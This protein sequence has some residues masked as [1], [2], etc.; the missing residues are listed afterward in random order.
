VSTALAVFLI[1]VWLLLAMLFL[2]QARRLEQDPS[3]ATDD[4]PPARWRLLGLGMIGLA[5]V[6]LVAVLLS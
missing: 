1:V 3:K 4:T 5:V 2:L 6:N